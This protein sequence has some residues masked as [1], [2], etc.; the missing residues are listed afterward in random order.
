MDGSSGT[1]DVAGEGGS[2]HLTLRESTQSL[3]SATVG[4]HRVIGLEVKQ[5]TK[6]KEDHF[7]L[8]LDNHLSQ[9]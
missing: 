1:V 8:R 7:F 9:A 2:P 3:D 4:A 5:S 6:S